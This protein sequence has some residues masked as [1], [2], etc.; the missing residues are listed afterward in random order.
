MACVY[1]KIFVYTD[2]VKCKATFWKMLNL[3]NIN[4]RFLLRHPES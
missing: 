3:A 4:W 1:K 2:K